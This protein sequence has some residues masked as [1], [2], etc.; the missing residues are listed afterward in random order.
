LVLTQ[1]AGNVGTLAKELA[2]M[3]MN[4]STMKQWKK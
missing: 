2:A 1:G 3:E 4:V